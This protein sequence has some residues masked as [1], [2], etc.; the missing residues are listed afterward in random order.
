[1]KKNKRCLVGTFLLLALLIAYAV[2]A[3]AATQRVISLPAGQAWRAMGTETRTGDYSYVHA[4]NQSV[5]PS[6]GTDDL[7]Y[8]H[9]RVLTSSGT[10]ISQSEYVK[11]DEKDAGYTKI[12]LREGYL[13][14]LEI[15][16]EFRADNTSPA[17]AVVS[18]YP[19]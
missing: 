10:R 16:F 18:Y 2:P 1:M 9:C 3:F 4:E 15:I 7:E 8:I 13:S 14:N 19:L 6:S 11:L 17:T 12:P 5:F